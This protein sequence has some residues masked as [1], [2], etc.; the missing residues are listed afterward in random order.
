MGNPVRTLVA[1][2]GL[3][4][5]DFSAM[6]GR[7]LPLTT[8]VPPFW[9]TRVLCNTRETLA[10][11][12]GLIACGAIF[13]AIQVYWANFMG[14]SLVDIASGIGTL[15]RKEGALFR[16]VLKHSLALMAL[17]GLI[18]VMYAYVFPG[19]VPDGHEY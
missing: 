18:V 19:A 14:P 1:V 11:W 7:I 10:V 8:L 5:E 6:L 3:R 9:L 12:P 16:A 17:V 4:E 2:T 15:L 13:G